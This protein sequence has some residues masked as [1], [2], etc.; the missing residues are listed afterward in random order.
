MGMSNK[1]FSL[2]Y[3]M[4]DLEQQASIIA[5]VRAQGTPQA[6]DYKGNANRVKTLVNQLSN[7]FRFLHKGSR[8]EQN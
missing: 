2:A 3:S 8:N 5:A 6:V 7:G 1:T 4:A